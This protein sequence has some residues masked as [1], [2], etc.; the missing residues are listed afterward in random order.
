MTTATDTKLQE[1]EK[2]LQM[3]EDRE[4]IRETLARYSFTADMGRSQEYVDNYTKDG[5]IDLA[6]DTKWSG[7]DGLMEFIG[8]PNG[9]HK[10]IENRC[11][12]TSVNTHVRV[13]GDTAWAEGYSVVYVLEDGDY[14]VFTAGYNHW[15]FK[16]EDSR[17]LLEYR[18]RRP[19]GGD[20]WGGDVIKDFLKR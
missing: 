17:W 7:P 11:M 1:L 16:R 4:K 18:H 13:E 19:V 6:P 12:H 8:D 3:L 10:A 5:V 2:R 20:E 9:G 15:R 14:R